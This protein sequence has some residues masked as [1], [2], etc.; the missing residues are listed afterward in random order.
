MMSS[1]GKV[2]RAEFVSS[3][4][5]TGTRLHQ[6]SIVPFNQKGWTSP[7]WRKREI[8]RRVYEKRKRHGAQ[9]FIESFISRARAAAPFGALMESNGVGTGS[10][11]SSQEDCAISHSAIFPWLSCIHL[12]GDQNGIVQI[13]LTGY[14]A[15]EL[16]GGMLNDFPFRPPTTTYYTKQSLFTWFLLFNWIFSLIFSER[17]FCR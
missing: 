7:C 15:P 5:V 2:P 1:G 3:D 6:P 4:H 17:I 14:R 13:L 16:S 10:N 8:F 12:H 11:R 9:T